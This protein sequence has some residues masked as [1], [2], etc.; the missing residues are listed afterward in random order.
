MDIG[1]I[2]AFATEKGASDLHIS[3]GEPPIVRIDGDIQ[4]IYMPSLNQE[5]LHTML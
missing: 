2:L 5:E 3:S 1:K 4:K